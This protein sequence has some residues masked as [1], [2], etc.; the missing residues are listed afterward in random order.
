MINITEN[1]MQRLNKSEIYDLKV[2]IDHLRAA[3]QHCVNAIAEYEKDSDESIRPFLLG[4]MDNA[5]KVLGIKK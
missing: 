5:K 2:E 3:L 1:L 4:A